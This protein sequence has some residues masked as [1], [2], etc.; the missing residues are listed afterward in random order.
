MKSKI[1]LI[2]L[3]VVIVFLGA[4]S[5]FFGYKYLDTNDKVN[6]LT[7]QVDTLNKEKEEIQAQINEENN[8]E[9]NKEAEPE[10]QVVEKLTIAKLDPNKVD[11][12]RSGLDV[13]EVIENGVKKNLSTDLDYI[14]GPTT[15]Y[16]GFT[17][18]Y[19]D[20]QFRFNDKT[21]NF[22]GKQIVEVQTQSHGAS[23]SWYIIVLLDDGTIRYA[24]RNYNTTDLDFKEYD[25]QDVVKI[26]PVA[27]KTSEGKI[28]PRVGAITSDGV[29]HVLPFE[30]P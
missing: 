4:L 10:I 25:L 30:L 21:Y 26:I 6:E 19:Y 1:T 2:I 27:V 18:D 15:S 8:E 23:S 13:E 12:S 9:D 24:L 22:D 7:A 16:P 14:V 29:T 11:I 28:I 20:F 3:I 5:F 17:I